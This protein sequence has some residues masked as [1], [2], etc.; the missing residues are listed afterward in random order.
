[1]A[2]MTQI[3]REQ[4]VAGLQTGEIDRHVRATP[5]VRL[6]VRVL[7][8]EQ[9]FGPLDCQQFHRVDVFA[10]PVPPAPGITFGVFV[11]QHGPLRLHHG[12]AGKVFAGDQLDILFLAPFLQLHSLGYLRI[13]APKAPGGIPSGAL[14]F[15]DPAFMTSPFK[16]C[17]QKGVDD[18]DGDLGWCFQLSQA[19][20]IGVVVATRQS[21]HLFVEDQGRPDSRHLVGGDAHTNTVR[22]HQNPKIVFLSRH[23]FRNRHRVIWIIGGFL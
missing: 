7:C 3:H 11:G 13:H 9:A 19:E 2:S 8:S 1:M 18:P 14:H 17:V 23:T 15:S 4:F 22:T 12:R 16:M 10:S 5:R 20:H 21:G 6:H